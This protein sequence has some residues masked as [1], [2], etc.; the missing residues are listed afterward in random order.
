M[1]LTSKHI[2]AALLS[3]VT[4]AACSGDMT[5]T[6]TSGTNPPPSDFTVAPA[7]S[8]C[9]G[10]KAGAKIPPSD[11]TT[12]CDAERLLWNYD[13][14][15]KTLGVSNARVVLNCCGDHSIKVS[16]DGDVIVYT[17]ID[18]PEAAAGGA[19]CGCECVFDYAADISPVEPGM[20]SLRIVR[21]VTDAPPATTP[22]EGFIDTSTGQGSIIVSMESA[23]PWCMK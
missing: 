3:I 19:R 7:I 15:T 23:D 21:D 4:I 18:A 9:G 14:T 12:Y 1:K 13:A 11:P 2:G 5:G 16:K 20:V 10:F 6:S 22:W 8:P 17:E